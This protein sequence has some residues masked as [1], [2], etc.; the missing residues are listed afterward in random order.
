MLVLSS[1][2]D[3]LHLKESRLVIYTAMLMNFLIYETFENSEL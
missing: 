2:V 1:N 3:L